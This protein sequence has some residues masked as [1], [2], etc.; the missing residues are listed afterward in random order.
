MKFSEYTIK[1]K[2]ELFEE[3][4]TDIEKG[5]SSQKA[6]IRRKRYGANTLEATS[7]TWFNILT[8]QFKSAFIYLLIA[9]A[10]LAFLLGNTFDGLMILLFVVINTVLG[11]YQEYKSEKALKY[12]K[13]LVVSQVKVLRSGKTH[14]LPANEIVPG[15]IIFLE[16]GDIVPADI[17]IIKEDNFY[18]DESS[19]TGESIH[20]KKSSEPLKNKEDQI[21]KAKNISFMGTT[22]SEGSATG[23]V[24][25]TGKNTQIGKIAKLT[26]ETVSKSGFE[27]HINKF[28]KFIL[29]LT[30][31][32]LVAVFIA[33]F[34]IK[35]SE[36]SIPNLLLFSI[37]LAVGVIPEA[38]PL[39]TTFSLT[40]G[41]LKLAKKKVVAKR[42]SA[43]EDLGSIEILCSDKTGTLTKN[44]LSVAE[45]FSKDEDRVLYY[46]A[47]AGDLIGKK[48]TSNNSFDLAIFK[49][50]GGENLL[51]AKKVSRLS[52]NPFNPTRRRNS[53]MVE[54][55]SENIIIVR[56]AHENILP[57]VD[58]M[59]KD[60]QEKIIAWVLEQGKKG[61]RV[62]AVASKNFQ[63]NDYDV[64][65]EERDLHFE[66]LISF[67]DPI[68]PSTKAAVNKAKKL[69]VK[70]K[71]ITG[72][73]AEVAGAVAYEVGI[74][75]SS[76]EVVTG[77]DLEKMSY[78]EKISAIQNGIVFARVSPEQKYQI[79]EVLQKE[80]IV[81]YLG[82]GINDAPA[83][84]L[85]NV[86]IV[87]DKASDVAREASDLIL[88]QQDLKVIV[89]G[90]E[91]GRKTFVNTSK[92]IKATL[93]SNF[94]N[95]YAVA[96]AS[97]LID[98]LPML[99]IQ[100][101]LVNLLSDF[102]MI[103]IATDNVDE[104]E[105][106]KPCKYNNS[107]IIMM[108]TFLGIVSTVF[109]LLI[110]AI[111]FKSSPEVLRTN[112]FIE[113]IL[114]ELA[115]LF[116]IRTKVP[117]LK[118]KSKPSK[119]ILTLTSLAAVSTIFVTFTSLGA[120]SFGFTT[121]S[122]YS[123]MIIGI[124][125]FGYFVSSEI[126]KVFYYKKQSESISS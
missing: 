123:L 116:S 55:N 85:A 43:I 33:H 99:P 52:E 71:I 2:E 19:L 8:R 59:P 10:V 87:V 51:K 7:V 26:V 92:Y 63:G 31:I 24:I 56:G 101:L 21:Y 113:S 96:F 16:V 81:G 30:L 72:D 75:K 125:I 65:D 108:A 90:I 110:F 109:D 4:F 23:I 84:K 11:F 37:A 107:E 126:V 120:R 111:F 64:K 91:E 9:A 122:L 114:T 69:G 119:I 38:L 95:F 5:L 29:I 36:V 58:D 39:V 62:I 6:A 18:I 86:A 104:S 28:S 20:V 73:S 42:L 22:V 93:S 32:T 27:Q 15:D 124:V 46:A 94:G 121:P 70:I 105:I 117:F 115:L 112:W 48:K 45:I 47:L 41:A 57:Y 88:F 77:F 80:H 14:Y 40:Q 35:G 68:K 1:N 17:R 106:E 54:V 3:F 74:V 53:V 50:I 76:S 12:L 100:I 66:G 44:S 60:Y 102:P 118:A 98:Y 61:R 25:F 49:K 82:D 89:D 103:S 79:I 67:S 97:L 83:L 13:G 34:L 78:Q